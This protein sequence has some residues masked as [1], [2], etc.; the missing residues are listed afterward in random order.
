[1]GLI[2]FVAPQSTSQVDSVTPF[3][4]YDI[5][6]RAVQFLFYKGFIIFFFSFVGDQK[7]TSPRPD[8]TG[9]AQPVMFIRQ[10]LLNINTLKMLQ[11]LFVCS[12]SLLC[13]T[14][15]FGFIE[16]LG[17]NGILRTLKEVMRQPHNDVAGFTFAT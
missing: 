3:P 7:E 12:S 9:I 5:I 16:A 1:M 2:R 15:F 11:I 13:E 17:W 14:N 8:I 6:N 10:N 4:Q